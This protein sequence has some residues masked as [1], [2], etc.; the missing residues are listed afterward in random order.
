[1]LRTGLRFPIVAETWFDESVQTSFPICFSPQYKIANGSTTLTT[2][3]KS[4]HFFAKNILALAI[5]GRSVS[6]FLE[7][8]TS[9]AK[10]DAAFSWSPAASAARAAP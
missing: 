10:Y 3:P 9:F 5:S 6:A 1:V 4:V 2:G 8:V 7:S